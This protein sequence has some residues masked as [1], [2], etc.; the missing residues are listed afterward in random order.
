MSKKAV[1]TVAVIVPR[2]NLM[3]RAEVERR[4]QAALLRRWGWGVVA[5][6]VIVALVGAGC[7]TLKWVADQALG[8]QQERSTTLLTQLASMSKVS[9][10]LAAEAQLESFSTEA[11]AE[12]V[13]WAQTLKSLDAVLPK[14]VAMTGFDLVPGAQPVKGT[15]THLAA[16]LAGQLT[17]TSGTAVDITPVIRS[18][19]QLSG[20]LSADGKE[21]SSQAAGAGQRSTY[22]YQLTIVFDQSAYTNG[23]K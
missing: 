16:G 19:R 5:A 21:L 14:G 23:A 6:L 3:P 17:M 7:F 2:V 4:Q 10:A 22:T 9:S 8:V 15:D 11:S 13:G 1:Q 12:N 18:I 20:V